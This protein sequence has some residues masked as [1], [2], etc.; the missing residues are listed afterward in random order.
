MYIEKGV[1]DIHYMCIDA[2]SLFKIPPIDIVSP[3]WDTLTFHL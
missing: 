3:Q 1:N 2:D